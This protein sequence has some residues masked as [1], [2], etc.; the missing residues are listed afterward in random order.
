MA[1]GAETRMVARGEE[2]GGRVTRMAEEE[3]KEEERTAGMVGMW[4]GR[5]RGA[6]G[7]S[8]GSGGR[9]WLDALRACVC[10]QN[11]LASQPNQN[12]F[13]SLRHED[14]PR[15]APRFANSGLPKPDDF[16]G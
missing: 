11:M 10:V 13:A 7:R 12:K 3:E 6:V 14:A 1:G 4:G 9:T 16:S 8:R 5:R 2:G 15:K